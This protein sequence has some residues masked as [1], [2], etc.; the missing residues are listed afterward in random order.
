MATAGPKPKPTALKLLEGETRTERL[1]RSEPSFGR[2]IPDPPRWL[3]RKAARQKWAELY[4]IFERAGVFQR[5]DVDALGKYCQLWAVAQDHTSLN[6][7][8]KSSR[9][10]RQYWGEFGMTPS[11]RSRLVAGDGEG[12]GGEDL[13]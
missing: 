9:E 5:S 12:D 2:P 8:I 3:K 10:L 7:L 11:A 1:N 4:P 6:D 13:D